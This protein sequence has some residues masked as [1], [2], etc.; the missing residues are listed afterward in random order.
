[1]KNFMMPGY[2]FSQLSSF[3]WLIIFLTFFSFAHSIAQPVCSG[4]MI[5]NATSAITIDGNVEGA[6]TK[7]PIHNITNTNIPNGATSPPN[8]FIGTRWRALYDASFLYFF[9]EV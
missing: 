1:M 2:F 4:N 5:P 6:W 9:V 7:A 3:K 8:D